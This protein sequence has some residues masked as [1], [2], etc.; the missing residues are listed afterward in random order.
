M[1]AVVDS[2]M[3]LEADALHFGER[4]SAAWQKSVEGILEAGA[5]LVQAKTQLPHGAFQK[6]IQQRC[7]FSIRTAQTL[8]QIASNPALSN[9]QHV[10]RLPASWGTLAELARFEPRELSHALGN[11]WVKP[12]MTRE[13]VGELHRRVRQALGGRVRQPL[14]RA[15]PD[16]R[17]VV[18]DAEILEDTADAA[19]VSQPRP[20]KSWDGREEPAP[21]AIRS[22]SRTRVDP[23]RIIEQT[24]QALEANASLLDLLPNDF[25][26]FKQEDR[27]H[28]AGSLR[29]SLASLNGLQK[30]IEE[31]LAEEIAP[32]D[33]GAA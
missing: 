18:V 23:H 17:E 14:P 8:M 7:P 3:P 31:S 26:S 6:M 20:R 33:G 22:R 32:G 24:V 2:V 28:W 16:D 12:D 19:S 5:L 21:A 25:S 11:R 4:I 10:A 1:S 9:A 15:V 30:K 13:D 27:E 29:E